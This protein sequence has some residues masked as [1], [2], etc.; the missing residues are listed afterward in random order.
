M[1]DFSGLKLLYAPTT[2]GSTFWAAL[3]S[4]FKKPAKNFRSDAEVLPSFFLEYSLFWPVF[5]ELKRN[6]NENVTNH[7]FLCKICNNFHDFTAWNIKTSI[8]R[9]FFAGFGCFL[10]EN[11]DSD[12][13][14]I[15]L[16]SALL[17]AFGQHFK[18]KCCLPAALW[19]Q[20]KTEFEAWPQNQV[21][22]V[23]TGKTLISKKLATIIIVETLK[24]RKTE[25]QCR[26][27]HGS[28]GTWDSSIHISF[29]HVKVMVDG[30]WEW[31]A[32]GTGREI[33]VAG[34][35]DRSRYREGEYRLG[36]PTT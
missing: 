13:F 34:E 9:Q 21:Q 7:H 18:S 20:I 8:F 36:V 30:G 24:I 27:A 32:R 16:F 15:G 5:H 10:P 28:K 3:G 35:R 19:S 22:N 26:P 6:L 14:N 4:T 25:T 11:D 23:K 12:D 33:P 1:L 29:I 31:C 17:S 2:L